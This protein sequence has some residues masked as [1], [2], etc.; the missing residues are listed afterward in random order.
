[1]SKKGKSKSI[2]K[3]VVDEEHEDTQPDSGLALH[4]NGY[5]RDDFVVSDH[6]EEEDAFEPVPPHRRLPFHRQQTLDELGPPIS[7]DARLAE[8]K[9]DDVHRDVI[10]AFVEKAREMEENLRN[11]HGLRRALFAEQQYQEMAMR[12]TT[13]VAQMYMIGGIDRSKVDR[14][15]AKFV[16]LVER[17]HNQYREMMGKT[18]T[19]SY[20]A[21]E[22][23]TNERREIVD[24]I[25]DDEDC[26]LNGT[27]YLD[28]EEEEDEDEDEEDLGS[29]RYF[30]GNATK[31]SSLAQSESSSIQQWHKRFEELQSK[32]GKKTKSSQSNDFGSGR[33]SGFGSNW[34]SGKK[35][36][37]KSRRSGG[38]GSGGGSGGSF[39]GVSKRKSGGRGATPAA[40][41][42]SKASGSK[43]SGPSSGSG[44]STMPY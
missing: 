9:L 23:V 17:F 29:S 12:W 41:S 18:S 11:K 26:T 27:R 30:S 22:M 44:I 33:R 10:Q 28:M 37:S 19:Q 2:A 24:L 20:S 38:G 25:S 15:G 16:P 39:G 32:P 42:R 13:S 14:Y 7:Q 35:S 8:A 1:V 40:G 3:T 36:F 21:A 6:E 34:K 31:P 4:G 43:K 5:E